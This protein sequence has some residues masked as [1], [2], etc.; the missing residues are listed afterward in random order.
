MMV[1]SMV[2]TVLLITGLGAASLSLTADYSAV[3]VTMAVVT[4][5]WLLKEFARRASFVELDAR[6]PL[7]IDGAAAAIQITGLCL[8][9]MRGELSAPSALLAAG[10]GHVS[11]TLIWWFAFHPAFKL[12]PALFRRALCL[13]WSFGSWACVGRLT[14]MMHAY[15]L[16][17]L[18]ALVSGP[19]ATGA[20]AAALSLLALANPV[21]MGIGNLLAPETARAYAAGGVAALRQVVFRAS[22]HVTLITAVFVVLLISCAE[23]LLHLTFGEIRDGQVAVVTILALGMLGGITGFGADNGLRALAR[24]ADSFKASLVGLIVSLSV[25]AAIVGQW[26]ATGA[27]LAALVGDLTSTLLRIGFF[28]RIVRDRTDTN[29]TLAYKVA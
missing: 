22:C 29:K 1:A 20:Y 5:F 8:L 25:A 28:I 26:D 2:S 19:A 16:H 7:L 23:P 12:R 3:L 11:A 21:L 14:D 24:P 6:R 10:A 9:W 15:S 17:W 13:N 27:A 18:L 4:P